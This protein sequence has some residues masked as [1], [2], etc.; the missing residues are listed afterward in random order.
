MIHL[1]WNRSDYPKQAT[2]SKEKLNCFLKSQIGET[3]NKLIVILANQFLPV[4]R[5]CGAQ[6]HCIH[7]RW[8]SYSIPYLPLCPGPNDWWSDVNL[9]HLRLSLARNQTMTELYT[10]FGRA[11]RHSV[12]T[13][14]VVRK[15]NRRSFDPF[16]SA[17]QPVQRSTETRREEG[18]IWVSGSM[19]KSG[20]CNNSCQSSRRLENKNL[21][22][23]LQVSPCCVAQLAFFTGLKEWDCKI[24]TDIWT[25]PIF[26]KIPSYSFDF[27][28]I[29]VTCWK[30][31]STP[32][33]TPMSEKSWWQQKVSIHHKI[34]K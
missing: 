26:R 24:T 31:S 33:E 25:G 13:N 12:I 21:A 8:R 17:N 4:V 9:V 18:S 2:F 22:W 30:L 7:R 15:S 34:A 20:E 5:S 1:F 28:T 23:L 3:P 14:N 32:E 27:R 29:R 16:S 10:S 19:S 6:V 11:V